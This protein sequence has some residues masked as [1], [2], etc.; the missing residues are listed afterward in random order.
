MKSINDIINEARKI[1]YRVS[2]VDLKDD[3]GLPITVEMSVQ[4]QYQKKFEQFLK[5][6]QDDA[7]IHAEGGN[8]EY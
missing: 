5:D 1:T 3:E 2:I 6:N 4:P 7:F 8:V